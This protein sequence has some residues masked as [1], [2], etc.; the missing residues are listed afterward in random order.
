MPH[1]G[2]GVLGSPALGLQEDQA[3]SECPRLVVVGTMTNFLPPSLASFL[4]SF[5]LFRA[6]PAAYGGSQVRGGVRS[7]AAGLHRNHSNARSQ[8]CLR[9][10]HSS[11][12]CRIIN[13]LSK[14]RVRTCVLTD[15]SQVLNPFSHNGNS[16]VT[17]FKAS[18]HEFCM[19]YFHLCDKYFKCPPCGTEDCFSS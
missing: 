2:L 3:Y 14:T 11:G 7:T 4:F 6:A 16:L 8:P 1:R 5:C 19:L 17:S 12:Q 10:P 15:T 13:P 9:L 18:G